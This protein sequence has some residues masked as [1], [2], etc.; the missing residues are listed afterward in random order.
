MDNNTF[1]KEE[2]I[3]V[4]NK[5]CKKNISNLFSRPVD[6]D[7]DGCTD[8]F[9]IVKS[10]MDLGTV[11]NKINNDEYKSISD[12]KKDMDLIWDNSITYNT[13]SNNDY[14]VNITKELKSYYTKLSEYILDDAQTSWYNKQVKIFNDIREI[15]R[16]PPQTY[17]QNKKKKRDML[18]VEKLQIP[19]N[20]G[21]SG[22]RGKEA[23]PQM[24]DDLYQKEIYRVLAEM[25]PLT[26]DDLIEMAAKAK[27]MASD[28]FINDKLIGIIQ[29][30]EP[31]KLGTEKIVKIDLKSLKDITQ[32]ALKMRIDAAVSSKPENTES[33]SASQ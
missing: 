18:V 11:N 6:P 32:K 7:I 31:E 1:R 5:I 14:F 3:H 27:S 26:E 33:K 10:P 20:S 13:K 28:K 25:S 12:W 23:T 30:Y 19:S 24:H 9:D 17:M 16:N 15:L 2:V 22:K 4:M 21:P 8:Y 29:Q